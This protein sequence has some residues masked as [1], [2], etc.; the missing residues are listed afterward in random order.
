MSLVLFDIDGTLANIDHRRHLVENEPPKWFEFFDLMGSDSVNEPVAG[1]YRE[2]WMSERYQ[3]VLVTGRPEQYR[4]VTEQWLIWNEIPFGRLIMRAEKDNRKDHLI[5]QEILSDLI[6]QGETIAFVVD[7]RQSVVDMW[8]RN[9]VTCLQC[10][11][12]ER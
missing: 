12:Y 6:S 3:C 10:A 4:A 2:L 5:K 11:V 1:L 9:G 8:R 7:D